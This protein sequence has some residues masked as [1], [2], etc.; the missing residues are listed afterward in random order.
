MESE[1]LSF[2]DSGS[3]LP[4]VLLHAFPLSRKMWDGE[5]GSWSKTHRV[6]APDWRGFGESKLATDPLTMESCADDLHQLLQ[7]LG[8]KQKAILLGLS[9]GGYVAFEFV[10]KYPESVQGLVLTAT[11]PI[12]DSEA[13]QKARYETAELVQREGAA[14]LAERLIPRLLGKT[15]L[16]SKPEVV[17]Q[18]RE[19][20]E[21]N[22]PSGIA[23]ACYGLASRRDSSAL[24]S[25]IRLPT[26]IV[27]G[28][29]DAIIARIQADTMHQ[30]IASSQMA[31]M[32]Q[33]GHLVN[34]EQPA[35]FRQA[36][37]NFLETF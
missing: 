9:M 31:V 34:L 7:K 22:S 2:I 33:S 4:L 37:A 30:G 5:I 27:A 1:Y 24:L 8:I 21:S 19:L 14:A 36:V 32:N 12:A 10:R 35:L 13:A 18:V 26:L 29:E 6:I 3:G 17:Q 16:Q 23:A 25:Q 28:D 20:I 11:Q 15:T